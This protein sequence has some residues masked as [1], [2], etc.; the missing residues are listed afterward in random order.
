MREICQCHRSHSFIVNFEKILHIGQ[1]FPML[2]L[3]NDAAAG[4]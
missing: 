3:N 4:G 1:M 2:T